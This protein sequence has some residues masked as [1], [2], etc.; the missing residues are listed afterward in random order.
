M[1]INGQN[2]F[3][4]A[5]RNK[6][7]P[8]PDDTYPFNLPIVRNLNTLEFS[9][10]VTYIVGENGSGKSTLLEAIACL[11][12]LNAEGGSKNINFRTQETHSS[13]FEELS[14]VRADLDYRNSFFFRAESFYNVAS[15]VDKIAREDITI[16]KSY[17]GESLHEQSHGESFM[18]LFTNRLRN[19]GLY[20]FDEPEAALSYM[21]QLRFLVWMKN[22][23]AAG[24]QIIISTHSPVIL[25]YP[26]AEI[27]VA[28]DGNLNST[29]YNDCYIFRDMLAFITN[30]DLVIKELFS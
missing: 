11:L 3:L 20:I 8:S 7:T 5:I 14:A 29:T 6:H 26:D 13:L 23:V 15:E 17:G 10:S 9:K 25:A 30:K 24:S 21:N 28:E 4:R 18:A 2:I 1:N 27:F 12:G 22:S 19:K 16:L